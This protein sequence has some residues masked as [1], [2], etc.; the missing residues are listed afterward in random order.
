MTWRGI[1]TALVAFIVAGAHALL[2]IYL[3]TPTPNRPAHPLVTVVSVAVGGAVIALLVSI[4]KEK[5]EAAPPKED[6]LS[7]GEHYVPFVAK[8]KKVS[9]DTMYEQLYIEMRRYRDH[10]QW[11]ATWY[12]TILLAILAA[13]MH[14]WTKDGSQ[15]LLHAMHYWHIMC[16]AIGLGLLSYAMTWL[17]LYTNRRYNDLR[18]HV[19]KYYDNI[20]QPRFDLARMWPRGYVRTLIPLWIVTLAC[21][22]LLYYV[23]WYVNMTPCK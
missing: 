2:S 3:V 18:A 10:E 12:T 21:W 17:I 19:K 6:Q 23:L 14:S 8:S 22:G 11:V 13:A 7:L 16:I 15:E 5:C 9:V 20:A 1:W 4:W